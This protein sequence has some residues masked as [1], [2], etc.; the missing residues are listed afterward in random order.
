MTKRDFGRFHVISPSVGCAWIVKRDI[1]QRCAHLDR[2]SHLRD[3]V[4]GLGT[5]DM[6]SQ[7]EIR[8]LD[9]RRSSRSLRKHSSVCGTAVSTV[10]E[11]ADFD[12]F[13]LL[14]RFRFAQA[15]ACNLGIG[16]ADA[17]TAL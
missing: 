2:Q 8:F 16:E 7:Y 17:G 15:D 13:A 1:L 11:L 12:R 5:D 6:R 10:H 4:G 9:R 3:E 14:L